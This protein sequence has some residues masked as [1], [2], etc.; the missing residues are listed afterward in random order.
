MYLIISCH[1][2]HP[3]LNIA[4]QDVRNVWLLQTPP[5]KLTTATHRGTLVYRHPQTG[6]RISY[7]TLKKGLLKQTITLQQP[8][9]LLPF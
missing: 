1:Y 5:L 6:R 4:M 3:G 7:R 9:H 2:Y 8:L